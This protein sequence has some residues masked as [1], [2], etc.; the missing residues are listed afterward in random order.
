MFIG[1]PLIT[2]RHML[3]KHLE[4][5]R[6][7]TTALNALFAVLRLVH[8][9]ITGNV[10]VIRFLKSHPHASLIIV[11]SLTLSARTHLHLPR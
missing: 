11:S 5:P 8:L 7:I 2:C 3:L 10:W 4:S 1:Y 6:I 9:A